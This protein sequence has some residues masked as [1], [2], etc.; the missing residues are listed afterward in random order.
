MNQRDKDNH[1]NRGGARR[2]FRPN[3]LRVRTEGHG[4]RSNG[5]GE[6]RHHGDDAGHESDGRMINLPQKMIFTTR[7]RQ[8]S[9][10]LRIAKRAT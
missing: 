2:K 7:T 3:P 1:G 4:A 9:G 6:P 8:R 10:E 5:C